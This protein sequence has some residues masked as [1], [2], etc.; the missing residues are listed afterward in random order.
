MRTFEN[1]NR[2]AAALMTAGAL[3][4]T[5]CG[6]EPSPQP[7]AP[8]AATVEVQ[9]YVQFNDLGG[10]SSIIQVYPGTT[11][12][13]ADRLFN[14]AYEDG[15]LFPVECKTMGREIV[16]NTDAG[17]VARQ[18]KEWYKL[19]RLDGVAQFATAVYADLQP[20]DAV[21]KSC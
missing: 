8:S 7:A 2:P 18:S 21:V 13:A 4:L 16:S 12:Q 14:D 1:M 10:G 19:K 9:P 17:E 5:G 11:E 15:D 6:S 20:A 3:A